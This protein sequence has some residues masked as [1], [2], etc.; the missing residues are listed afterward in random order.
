MGFEEVK[1]D[2]VEDEMREEFIIRAP[3][4]CETM[5]SGD[6]RR[7]EW[8]WYFI[9]QHFGMATRLLDWTEGALIALY[10]AV[11]H[12]VGNEDAAVWALDP[13]KLN[14][15]KRVIGKDW[16]IPMSATGVKWDVY[17][18]KV[19]KWLPTRFTNMRGLPLKPVAVWPTHVVRRISSQHSCFTL[20]GRDEV[21]LDGLLDEKNP[22]LVKI[23]IRGSKV[24]DIK[25]DLRICGINESTIFPDLDGLGRSINARWGIGDQCCAD[26][27]KET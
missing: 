19:Q 23:V 7:A 15:N 24:D 8:E 13:Y 3:I 26:M 5:P 27:E 14:K 21:G 25:K 1:A 9:M 10:F 18:E 4:L 6:E 2:N 17:V 11:R 22:C 12:N 20:H 16:V